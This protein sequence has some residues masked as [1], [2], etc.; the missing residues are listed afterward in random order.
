MAQEQATYRFSVSLNL[1]IYHCKADIITK[2][3]CTAYGLPKSLSCLKMRL[4][5]ENCVTVEVCRALYMTFDV[6]HNK[7]VLKTN[8]SSS[9]LYYK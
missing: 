8:D 3:T 9:S 6:V 2:C 1:K 4:K 7:Y 5:R